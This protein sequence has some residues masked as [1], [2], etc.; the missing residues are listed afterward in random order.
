M[1]SLDPGPGG[2]EL[3]AR[4][5]LFQGGLLLVRRGDYHKA[6]TVFEHALRQ[7]PADARFQSYFGLCLAVTGKKIRV[8][9]DL[10][11]QAV[12]AE[13]YRADHYCNL[14]RVYELAGDRLRAYQAYRQGLRIEAD[15]PEIRHALA[16]MGRRKPPPLPFLE[17]QHPINRTVGMMLARLGLR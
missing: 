17:R 16:K 3:F 11:E 5:Q 1:E 9:I 4:E 6:L 13:F 12:R 8:A 10:C 7:S 14:G 2:D 15:H